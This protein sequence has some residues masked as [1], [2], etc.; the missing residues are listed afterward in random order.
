[1]GLKEHP[2]IGAILAV[3]AAGIDTMWEQVKASSELLMADPFCQGA[4]ENLVVG[5]ASSPLK[6]HYSLTPT[7]GRCRTSSQTF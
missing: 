1:M 2:L 7:S 4:M 5:V 3:I 6:P